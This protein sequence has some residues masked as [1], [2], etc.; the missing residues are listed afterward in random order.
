MTAM[1]LNIQ[2][3]SR[4]CNSNTKGERLKQ[5]SNSDSL[6]T[7][8]DCP[9][10]PFR[11]P[12]VAALNRKRRVTVR[13]R[14]TN[15]GSWIVGTKVCID[16]MED[17]IW[18]RGCHVEHLLVPPHPMVIVNGKLNQPLF[19]FSLN[20]K[21]PKDAKLWEWRFRSPLIQPRCCQKVW[22]S[23]DVW[24]AMGATTARW[25]LVTRDRS[26]TEAAEC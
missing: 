22:G 8:A 12:Y 18:N 10:Q 19:T 6:A 16:Y 9:C 21:I 13:A 25:G 2:K 14:M 1:D 23:W 20:D 15:P 24:Q 11:V 4:F 7:Q 17:S 5:G 3:L 26:R